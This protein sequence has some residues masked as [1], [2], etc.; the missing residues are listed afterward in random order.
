MEPYRSCGRNGNFCG[1]GNRSMNGCDMNRRGYASRSTQ[2]C[3]SP[4]NRNADECPASNC[5]IE[6]RCA[7][8][9][10]NKEECGC[11]YSPRSNSE[12][13][14]CRDD[15]PHMRHMALGM[16][17][18]QMQPWE[19]L[20]E[21]DTALCQGTAFPSLNLIFCGIRGKK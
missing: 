19:C 21:P 5:K 2:D 1:Q 20:S 3:C 13:D 15:N 7:Y 12:Y 18:V 4:R 17:Y 14:D 16:A 8:V 6:E 9:A 10:Q 11:V